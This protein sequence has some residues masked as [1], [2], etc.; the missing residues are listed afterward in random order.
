MEFCPGTRG[1]LA[2]TAKTVL[3]SPVVR[4][5]KRG[6][7]EQTSA[8]PNVNRG[9]TYKVLLVSNC[10]RRTYAKVLERLCPTVSVTFYDD[11]V[12]IRDRAKF[13]KDAAAS[14]AACCARPRTSSTRP[15]LST[16]RFGAAGCARIWRTWS[17][18]FTLL[19][20]GASPSASHGMSSFLS[21]RRSAIAMRG[22]EAEC[23]DTT[24][25]AAG[26]GWVSGLVV[27]ESA[28]TDETRVPSAIAR[29]LLNCGLARGDSS[30]IT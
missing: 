22:E 20:L 7:G 12:A 3:P 30:R 24:A 18:M 23:R 8:A 19:P 17:G 29:F 6:A 14:D 21:R 10:A 2:R 16:W 5:L 15:G 25:G 28:S 13:L 11:R 9:G 27:S 4:F 1:I 26:A